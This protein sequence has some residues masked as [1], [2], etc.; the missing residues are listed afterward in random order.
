MIGA[1][2]NERRDW[3]LLIFIIPIGILLIILVG[4]LAVRL[5]PFWSVNADMNSN[6][7]PDP[8]SAHPFA[9][10]EP[11]LPQILTPMAWAQTYL[12]PGAEI[13]FPP[14][15]TFEP[16]S[17]P[18][19]TPVTPTEATPTPI[20]TTSTPVPTTSTGTPPSPTGTEP[21][22]GSPTSPPTSDVL[23]CM[24]S[25]A[26]NYDSSATV[27]DGSCTYNIFGCTDSGASNYDSSA[28]VDD[29]SCTYDILGCKDKSAWNYDPSATI[30]DGSCDYGDVSTIDT[31]VY[32]TP[33]SPVPTNIG[34]G[35]APDNDP[36]TLRD[37]TY[38]VIELSVVVHDTPDNKY[39]LVFYEYNF[40]DDG[41]V[42]LDAVIIGIS[43]VSDG[44]QY[45]EVFRWGDT[46]RDENSNVDTADLTPSPGC[47]SNTECDGRS[48]AVNDPNGLY[49]GTG[50]LIDVDTADSQ[51]P[52]ST[53]DNKYDYIVIISPPGSG[54]P[55][56]GSDIDSI[57]TVDVP[58]P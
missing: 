24:D 47:L 23:G 18:S 37:G 29:G 54:N 2:K 13:S 19:P 14:F 32:G 9:L 58:I 7:E 26:R 17:T 27:D 45:Y 31:S 55:N 4:Q 8:A 25:A 44:S 48:F 12:T 38:L 40:N 30:D 56:D 6:L 52:P 21:P 1:E 41:Y 43:T 50:I 15:L 10:L 51:P 34:V 42:Y 36:Y 33:I 35:T 3:T 46:N 16:T 57:Q 20:A 5:V 22:E 49:N 39:D 28:T 11:I 53:T